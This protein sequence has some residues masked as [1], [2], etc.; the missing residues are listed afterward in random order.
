MA[1]EGQTRATTRR[2]VEASEDTVD[3]LVQSTALQPVDQHRL[4]ALDEEV[5]EETLFRRDSD[6]CVGNQPVRVQAVIGSKRIEDVEELRRHR[7][8][9]GVTGEAFTR[10]VDGDISVHR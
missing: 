7:Q 1:A 8:G 5:D 3:V 10:N 4:V 2:R 9:R 6:S